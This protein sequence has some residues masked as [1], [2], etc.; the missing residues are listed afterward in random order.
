[1]C[2]VE[3]VFEVGRWRRVVVWVAD[4]VD[5]AVAVGIVWALHVVTAHALGL[6]A[7]GVVGKG[8]QVRTVADGDLVLATVDHVVGE[9][10]VIVD[11]VVHGFDTIGVVVGELWVVWGLD[12]LIDDAVDY[13]EGVEGE[14]F[15]LGAAVGYGLVL[16]VEVVEE[17]WA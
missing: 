14:R 17:G 7:D 3:V 4:V 12:H 2:E 6:G 8:G 13:S 10:L 16:F 1:M 15:A 11:G 9:L 5:A